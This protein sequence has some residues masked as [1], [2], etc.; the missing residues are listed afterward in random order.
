MAEVGSEIGRGG[1]VADEVGGD[2]GLVD[3]GSGEVLTDE[4]AVD[5]SAGAGIDPFEVVG[6]RPQVDGVG[7]AVAYWVGVYVA[8][9]VSRGRSY[10]H[11]KSAPQQGHAHTEEQDSSGGGEGDERA[12]LCHRDTVAWRGRRRKRAQP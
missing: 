7:D 6:V 3:G 1:G 11:T 10:L 9:E 5:E 8:A 2:V 4:G 12:V